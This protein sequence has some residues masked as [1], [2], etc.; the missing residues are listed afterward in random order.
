MRLCMLC[1]SISHNK[2]DFLVSFGSENRLLRLCKWCMQDFTLL[3]VK[4]NQIVRLQEPSKHTR[5][6]P[7]SF[8]VLGPVY[9]SLLEA[10]RVG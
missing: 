8:I 7:V 5:R 10:K 2:A 1:G 9:T 6:L 3:G 4:L